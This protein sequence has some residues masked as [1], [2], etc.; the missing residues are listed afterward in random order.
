MWPR[1]GATGRGLPKA[2]ETPVADVLIDRLR[3]RFQI[4]IGGRWQLM[5]GKHES[6]RQWAFD[7]F[8]GLTRIGQELGPNP[9]AKLPQ[10]GPELRFLLDSVEDGIDE[11]TKLRKT[12]WI[13]RVFWLRFGCR[14][15]G[16]D[17]GFGLY[18]RKNAA[19]KFPSP[20]PAQES[21]Q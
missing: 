3:D 11:A 14:L 1:P 12:R 7:P 2:M 9:R 10:D 8:F 5:P 19:D 4:E 21:A 18:W 13:S 16:L 17:I 20:I 15:L 6:W